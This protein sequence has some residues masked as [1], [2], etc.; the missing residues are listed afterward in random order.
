MKHTIF[1]TGGSG[2]IGS[3]LVADFVERDDVEKIIFLDK[4]EPPSF[5]KKII[6]KNKERIVFIKDNMLS[7]SW[8]EKVSAFEP[9]TVIHC[10]WQIR[11]LFKKE[12]DQWLENILGSDNVFDFAFDTPSV[13]KLIHFSTVAS[14]SALKDNS[15]SEFFDEESPLRQS[16]FRYAYEKKETENR[17]Y[18]KYC[19][20][21]SNR[22]D[23][24]VFVVRPASITGGHGR[25][26][27]KFGL[28]SILSGKSQN[29]FHKIIARILFFAPLTKKWARQFVHE[30][31]V[32]GTVR[33]LSFGGENK[34]LSNYEIFN[35]CP[36]GEPMTAQDMAKTINKKL[37]LLNPQIIRALFF[38]SWYG[39]RGLV[40]TSRGAWQSYCYPIVVDGSK[41]TKVCGYEY[42][43][44]PKESFTKD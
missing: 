37:L 21:K 33:L 13:K 4:K 23:L 2:Y 34:N 24:R 22:R 30:S 19:T 44:G 28:Q 29:I 18:A 3:L 14:Y 27:S 43:Y 32:V 16:T 6:E 38:L 26:L 11:S 42:R 39:T 40:P 10:A 12:K 25:S 36:P 9:D 20:Q 1:I 5:L 35:L 17:L 31:D 41:I 7:L 15:L 8:R